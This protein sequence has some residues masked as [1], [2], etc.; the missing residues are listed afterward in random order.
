MLNGTRFPVLKGA[1]PGTDRFLYGRKSQECQRVIT[2][3][4]RVRVDRFRHIRTYTQCIYM[5]GTIHRIAP[6][7]PHST[8]ETAWAGGLLAVHFNTQPHHSSHGIQSAPARIG[9]P[10]NAPGKPHLDR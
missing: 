6:N 10:V 5:I 3:V 2:G 7:G 9:F 8:L 4:S 1:Q